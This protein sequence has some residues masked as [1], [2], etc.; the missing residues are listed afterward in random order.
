MDRSN[1]FA[2]QIKNSGSEEPMIHRS[3]NHWKTNDPSSAN[4][5]GNSKLCECPA[6]PR[7]AQDEQTLCSARIAS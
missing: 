6:T 7:V 4:S 1:G 5:N 2:S 3:A